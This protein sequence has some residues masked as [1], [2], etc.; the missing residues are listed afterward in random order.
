VYPYIFSIIFV[1][2]SIMELVQQWTLIFLANF[3]KMFFLF[4]IFYDYKLLFLL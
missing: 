4:F 2:L 1:G 3:N